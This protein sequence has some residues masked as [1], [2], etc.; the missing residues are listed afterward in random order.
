MIFIPVTLA[1]AALQVA[2]NALQRSLLTG[3]GPWGATLVRFLFGLP[4]SLA[5]VAIAWAIWPDASPRMGLNFWGPA[6]VGAAAQLGA[7]AALLSAMGRSGFALGTAF[8]QSSLPFAAVFGLLFLGETLGGP[9]WVGVAMASAGILALSWPSGERRFGAGA[10]LGLLSGAFYAVALN[11]FRVAN[12]AVEPNHVLFGAVVTAS[13]AQAMQSA[14]LTAWL[15]WR[16]RK[17]LTVVLKAWRSSLG[18]GFFGSAASALWITALAL[19]PAG[20]VRAVGVVE[21]PM[22]AFAGRRLFAERLS[23]RQVLLGAMTALGVVLAALG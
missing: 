9:A 12:L 15:Y 2:R 21:M 4:F 1:A 13:A 19:A 3:A 7:T 20:Q 17:A 11:A 18:A 6:I 23:S 5:F 22:A 16:D 14:G 8:Q 10:L